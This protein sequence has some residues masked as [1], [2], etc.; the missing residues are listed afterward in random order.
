MSLSNVD[1]TKE[2]LSYSVG[3]YFNRSEVSVV[4]TLVFSAH[5]ILIGLLKNKD[6]FRD[7]MQKDHPQLESKE[8][9]ATWNE[10]WGFLKHA[11]RGVVSRD[12]NEDFVEK[13]L[14]TAIHDFQ[15]LREKLNDNSLPKSSLEM[16]TYQL[17]FYAKNSEIFN[18]SKSKDII[19]NADDLFPNIR[20]MSKN[21]QIEYG[22]RVL[23]KLKKD[24]VSTAEDA[25]NIH[26]IRR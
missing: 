2:Q 1:V 17:W 3:L 22:K 9:W 15:S 18:C 12:I 11:R 14:F 5:G 8:I 25:I 4:A 10:E 23:E 16:E 20:D 26:D 24:T 7:W 21:K 13:I 19:K 6:C